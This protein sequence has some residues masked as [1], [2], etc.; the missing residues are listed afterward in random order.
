V[1]NT[2]KINPSKGKAGSFTTARAKDSPNYFLGATKISG[3]EKLK[4]FRSNH[5][6]DLSWDNQ[7]NCTVQ[8]IPMMIFIMSIV[9]SGNSNAIR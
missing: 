2:T 5:S 3:N 7:L 6:T 9:K 8:K 1:Q 4:I